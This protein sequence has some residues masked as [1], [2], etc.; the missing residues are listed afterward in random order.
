MKKLVF[1]IFLT[2]LTLGWG[3]MIPVIESEN[4]GSL[5]NL[6]DDVTV[7]ETDNAI[8]TSN[9]HYYYNTFTDM[10]FIFGCFSNFTPHTI[11]DIKIEY[12]FL[13]SRFN[14]ATEYADFDPIEAGAT[15]VFSLHVLGVEN[16][17]G[18]P[19]T[20]DASAIMLTDLRWVSDD[21]E[22]GTQEEDISF[23][24]VGHILDDSLEQLSSNLCNKIETINS[25]TDFPLSISNFAFYE[26]PVSFGKNRAEF[27]YL[28]GC[29]TNLSEH[30]FY[31]RI[32]G[33]Y[34]SSFSDARDMS[35]IVPLLPPQQTVPF[36]TE[37]NVR[38][39][40]R[41]LNFFPDNEELLAPIRLAQSLIDEE[42][43]LFT[44]QESLVG[45]DVSSNVESDTQVDDSQ[46]DSAEVDLQ[47]H[48]LWVLDRSQYLKVVS[49][50][51]E[52]RKEIAPV[53]MDSSIGGR[54]VMATS[55]DG[56]F[57]IA[58]GAYNVIDQLARYNID[59][60]KVWNIASGRYGAVDI[61]NTNYV[62]VIKK[63]NNNSGKT[64]IQKRA[65]DTGKI[66]KEIE[67]PY[68]AFDIV[69]DENNKNLWVAGQAISLLDLELDEKWTID[70][71]NWY[72]ISIDYASDGA[73]LAAEGGKD[74]LLRIDVTG[75][76]TNEFPLPSRPVKLAANR[77]NGDVWVLNP[78]LKL[79]HTGKNSDFWGEPV[80]VE[81]VAGE[82]VEVVPHNDSVWVANYGKI[83]NVSRA[84]E[85]LAELPELGRGQSNLAVF[86]ELP[87][88]YEADSIQ[89]EEVQVDSIEADMEK[90][91][92]WVLDRSQHLS[93]VSSDGE[94]RE[95]IA[96]VNIDLSIGGNRVMAVSH[97]GTF[98]VSTSA[99]DVVDKLARYNI[100]GTKVW[101]IAAG[102]YVAVDIA[103]TNYVYAIKSSDSG[104]DIVQKIDADTGEVEKE[105]ELP[106]RVF[107]I[108]VDE[109]NENLWVAGQAI[110]FFDLEL[111]EAWTIDPI[112]WYAVSVDYAPDGTLLVAE[113]EY[114]EGKGKNRLL[115]INTSGEVI[116][117]FALD[118][119][120]TRLV[121]SRGRWDV[122]VL[123]KKLML[124]R[125]KG[126]PDF[127]GE[128]LLTEDIS[129]NYMDAVSHDGSV[130]VASEGKM[131]N[132]SRAGEILGEIPSLGVK[133]SCFT[134][135]NQ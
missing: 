28:V 114:L 133:K 40:P 26:L 89:A 101:S 120:P 79:F 59:G 52:M 113:A 72:I 86:S 74:R 131:V 49:S 2:V 53:T 6:C 105:I 56:S 3:R 106:Y 43:I 103:K 48:F 132:V 126:Q 30:L 119:R 42:P 55:D 90:P 37:T 116:N 135:V 33:K 99:Y 24:F 16:S 127:W 13:P 111:D 87:P 95:E 29:I 61:A 7:P 17:S 15:E 70:P 71:V 44:E 73:L 78:K 80:I 110:S 36:I 9:L 108:V 97:D 63:G 128:P 134:V 88:N 34:D 81:K 41:R 77:E 125:P 25:D 27:M 35:L 19:I 1:L 64:T 115:R 130:W 102:N 66:E 32:L 118:F 107:D 104:N 65:T 94:V 117:E 21:G 62:Y 39:S 57:A 75:E 124:F 121:S 123:G 69:V 68:R 20:L 109:R 45:N 93:V 31:E 11:D 82:Y 47:K 67:L 129:G 18:L 98:A 8:T 38:R 84:G 85:I 91:F 96:P 83:L 22:R 122:W 76:I 100:D 58:T 12:A 23:E 4:K 112:Q 54:R 46:V 92:L 5:Q 10:K 51:G 60:T 14:L 50:D